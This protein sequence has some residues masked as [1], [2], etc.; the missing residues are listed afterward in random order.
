M[1]INDI[2]TFLRLPEDVIIE[3][4]QDGNKLYF[5]SRGSCAVSV[6]NYLKKNE[7]VRQLNRGAHFG[8]V[9]LLNQCK[10][11]ATVKSSN[12][13]TMASLKKERFYDLCNSFPDILMNMKEYCL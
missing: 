1:Y 12:Y 6:K 9:S 10:T 13:C 8:E 7:F 5:I 4:G 2:D 3:Q 11:S